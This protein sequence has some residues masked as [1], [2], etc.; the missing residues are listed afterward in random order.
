MREKRVNSNVTPIKPERKS[1]VT[2]VD[3]KKART[4]ENK[5][6]EAT[7]LLNGSEPTEHKL[8]SILKILVY[9]YDSCTSS[10]MT[11][12]TYKITVCRES[13]GS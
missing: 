11:F 5:R 8:S 12:R 10:R 7:N 2:S 1:R 4:D 13:F 9:F 6:E 3:L